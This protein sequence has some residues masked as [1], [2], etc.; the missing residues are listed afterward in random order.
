MAEV[1][2]GGV[3]YDLKESPF[4]TNRWGFRFFFSSKSHKDKFDSQVLKKELWLKDS[5][6]RRFH[7]EFD[8]SLLACV[9]FYRQVETRGFCVFNLDT[10]RYYNA[11]GD[12]S[13]VIED[14]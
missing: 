9:H 1:T 8:V 2:R 13:F 14:V 11:P 12:L 5:M 4:F 7:T 6:E 10:W 3:C